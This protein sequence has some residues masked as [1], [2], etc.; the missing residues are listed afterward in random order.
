MG[1]TRLLQGQSWAQ[2]Y[3][4]KV[5]LGHKPTAAR[6]ILGT[7]LLLQGQS[8]AQTD[9]CKVSLGHK[10]T[11]ARSVLGPNRL[12]QGKLTVF[13]ENM[14][15]LASI[16]IILSI[17]FERYYAVCYPLKKYSTESRS[18][19]L[20][21]M[22]VMWLTAAV[23]TSPMLAIAQTGIVMHY[24]E[25]VEVTVCYSV[26]YADWQ[27]AYVIVQFLVV[28]VIPLCLLIFVYSRI[29]F[30]V[31]VDTMGSRQMTD[32]VRA[33]VQRSRQ[34]LVIMLVGIIVLFFVCLLPFRIVA[35]CWTFKLC[36]L[37][38]E[39]KLNLLHLF[40]LL[41]YINSAGNPIIY[42]LV[43]TKFR[44]AFSRVLLRMGCRC[45]FLT[46]GNRLNEN[47]TA[48]RTTVTNYTSVRQ[49]TEQEDE[50]PSDAL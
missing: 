43:S 5:S 21:L 30:K 4:C 33:Q 14:V 10:P 42:S 15:C 3:C 9:C 24:V 44:R 41:V 8:W 19:A 1:T 39:T 2:T 22:L 23:M 20:I 38:P 45:A 50:T 34:Q 7:D 17:S 13:L 12:L 26:V 31:A 36:P 16:L 29:I 46:P 6:S 37:D 35:L 11:A 47:G 18:K 49:E 27:F 32:T 28:F 48:R 25:M 40:R